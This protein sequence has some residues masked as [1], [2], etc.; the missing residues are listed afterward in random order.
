[1]LRKTDILIAGGGKAGLATSRCPGRLKPDQVVPERGEVGQ[2]RGKVF[3][4]AGYTV[5]LSDPHLVDPALGAFIKKVDRN[6]HTC[7]NS[8]ARTA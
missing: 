2:C 7:V 8:T 6:Q 5:P 3:A 1:M 4:E